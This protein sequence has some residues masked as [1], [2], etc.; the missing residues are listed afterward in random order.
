[1]NTVDNNHYTETNKVQLLQSDVKGRSIGTSGD[2]MIP[3][4]DISNI[5]LISQKCDK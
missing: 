1:M 4:N 3:K 5:K 2:T